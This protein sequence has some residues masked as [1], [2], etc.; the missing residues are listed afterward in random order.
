MSRCQGLGH[1]TI[2]A[3]ETEPSTLPRC[4]FED[5]LPQPYE[6]HRRRGRW[7]RSIGSIVI[8]WP[9][10]LAPIEEI[11]EQLLVVALQAVEAARPALKMPHGQERRDEVSR[12]M[13]PTWIELLAAIDAGIDVDQV[14]PAVHL[15]VRHGLA[16]GNSAR[17]VLATIFPRLKE[18]G[19]IQG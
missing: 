19:A 8:P 11:G 12:V 1:D 14:I 5:T 6:T 7:G 16:L 10:R 3:P 13:S 2:T 18:V 4:T 17:A 15:L 9:E